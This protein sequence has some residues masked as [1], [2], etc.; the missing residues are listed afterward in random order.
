MDKASVHGEDPTRE[1][2]VVPYYRGETSAR[3]APAA[4]PSAARSAGE[5]EVLVGAASPLVQ[6]RCPSIPDSPVFFVSTPRGSRWDRRPTTRLRT[7][8]APWTSKRRHHPLLARKDTGGLFF[9]FLSLYVCVFS[10]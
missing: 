2:G 5:Q 10:V 9:T 7:S 4:L 1:L 8:A 6:P 3:S